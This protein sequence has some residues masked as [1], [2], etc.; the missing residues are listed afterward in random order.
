MVQIL[1]LA[2]NIYYWLHLEQISNIPG[3]P[4]VFMWSLK[5]G[6][7]MQWHPLPKQFQVPAVKFS[8]KKIHYSSGRVKGRGKVHLR[9]FSE[10]VFIIVN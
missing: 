2:V 3:F 10:N 4:P 8:K 9:I 7:D 1:I 5:Q 6:Q